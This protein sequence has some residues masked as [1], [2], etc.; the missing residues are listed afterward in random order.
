MTLLLVVLTAASVTRSFASGGQDATCSAR[1]Q[2]LMQ[3]A[4]SL[5][6]SEQHMQGASALQT[7]QEASGK[8]ET[9]GEPTS[10]FL[11]LLASLVPSAEQRRQLR[12]SICGKFE[13][14]ILSV[15]FCFGCAGERLIGGVPKHLLSY[16]ACGLYLFLSVLIDISIALQKEV[17]DTEAPRE[18]YDFEPACMC[19][20]VEV[21]KFFISAGLAASNQG[22]ESKSVHFADAK[23][24]GLP[25]AFFTI[26]NLLVWKAL[27]KN[28][29]ATFGVLR[30]C[31]ILWTA[32]M[33][34]VVF[35]V[36]LGGTRWLAIGIVV[37]GLVFNRI[38]NF[39]AMHAWSWSILWILLMTFCNVLGSVSNEFALKRNAALD[40]NQQNMVLYAG[41]I[42]CTLIAIVLLRPEKLSSFGSFF[43][44][45]ALSTLVLACLQASA[46][47]VVSRALKYADSVTKNVAACLRGPIVVFLGPLILQSTSTDLA[48]FISAGVVATGCMVYLS[49]GPMAASSKTPGA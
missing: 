7:V 2:G 31:M 33:W 9:A 26:N 27:G 3:A 20:L 16:G 45:F 8:T 14:L 17:S 24:M 36:P 22:I 19:L 41:C 39:Y 44:G 15:L 42:F 10:S 18:T 38:S 43:Q 11:E 23:W 48:S 32:G 46:G 35:Q 13:I 4:V 40:L 25:V 1:T 29:I 30:D 28:D 21:I 49:E 34:R 6:K 37:A 47:L 12:A 5:E